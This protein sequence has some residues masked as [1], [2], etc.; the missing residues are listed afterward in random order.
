[1]RSSV[2]VDTVVM[3]P[4]FYYKDVTDD[5]LFAGYS[6]V[7]QRIGDARL[8]VVLYH[9]PQM[10][11]QPI[12][13]RADRAAAR[14]LSRALHRHQGFAPAISRNMTRDWSS[15][16]RASPCWPAPIR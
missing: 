15:D 16:S 2:G 12:P 3:L 11:A 6:E 4:P 14:G 8:S 10:S 9:I 1:M 5:G 13:L 7:V